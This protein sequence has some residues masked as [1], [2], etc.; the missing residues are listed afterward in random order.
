MTYK[1]PLPSQLVSSS[2]D[3][4]LTLISL[5]DWAVVTINGE[6]D[7]KYLQGQVSC[8]MYALKPEH[9]QLTAHCDA[10]GKMWSD[11]R[12]FQYGSGLAYIQR[13]SVCDAQLVELKKYAVFSKV[14]I[15]RKKD[16][17]L[18]GLAGQDARTALAPF[19]S[20]LPDETTPVV[21]HGETCILHFSSPTE[22]F[23]I[24]TNQDEANHIYAD[25]LG[26]AALNNSSQWLALDIEAGIPVIDSVNSGQF[27]PQATNLQALDGISF[28][29]GCYAG[30]EMI[31]RAKYRG[32]NKRAMYWLAGKALE[33]P[34]V[35]DELELQ[36]GENWRRTGTIL[37]VV[38]LTDSSI[39]VQAILNNDLEPEAQLRV[40]DDVTSQLTIQI[41]PYLLEEESKA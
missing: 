12:L 31:A 37:A 4:L 40:R 20:T 25:L 23:L 2:S 38:K 21:Q 30:Q 27:I 24:V 41:L 1:S 33:L 6:D 16:A 5:E 3:L 28:T 19:F 22:R 14:T 34:N 18:L 10:K 35:G 26:K 8:D 7:R 17:V 15:E 11:I 36:L 39:W 29:K 9:H 13:A 32:A